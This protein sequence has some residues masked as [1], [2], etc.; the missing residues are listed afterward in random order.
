MNFDY[1]YQG[2]SGV[3]EEGGQARVALATNT[4]REASYFRGVL[5][6]PLL[7]REGFAALFDVVQSD[8]KWRPKERLAYRLWLEAQDRAFVEQFA[9]HQQAAQA[10]IAA[11][12]ARLDA[13]D[14]ARQE[15][16][17]DFRSARMRY[18]QV[19]A[20]NEM[21][22]YRV[23]DPVI[24]IHPDEMSF[25][26]FSRDQ[27]SYARLRLSYELFSQI[28]EY[29]CGTTNIDFSRSL[30]DHLEGL[31]SY[32]QTRFDI[33][34]GGLS[35][36][37][38]VADTGAP[39]AHEK[40]IALPEGWLEGFLNVH[41][42]ISMGLTRLQ[43]APIDVLNVL[44]HLL[45]HRTRQSPRA[46][47]FELS[48]GLPVRV[49]LEPWEH[50][51]WCSP[52]SVYH[53]HQPLSWRIW[54]RDRLRTL[55]R[56]LPVCEQV[57]VYLAGTGLPS[58][59]VANLGAY[60]E[61]TLA[62]SGWTDNDWVAGEGRFDPLDRR[63]EVSPTQLTAVHQLLQALRVCE[64]DDLAARLSLSREVATA[65][66]S[67]LAQDGRAMYDLRRGAPRFR[68]LTVTPFVAGSALK[69][70][71]QVQR[72]DPR[73]KL[74]DAL[75]EAKQITI[76]ARRPVPDGYKLSGNCAEDLGRQQRVRPQLHISTE[77]AI[78]SASCTCEAMQRNGMSKGVCA[79]VLA[80]RSAHLA[81]LEHERG[82]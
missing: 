54:G 22:A 9:S 26:A 66:V 19:A 25:E 32:R 37:H 48:P 28:D 52:L 60:A 36:A 68:D 71:R 70:Q 12:R 65:A 73:A 27:S 77:G 46:L 49:V 59:W 81:R 13:L 53:G 5:A 20:R 1:R 72:D 40:R 29:A 16:R 39:T 45:A 44:K 17:R 69:R 62:L 18:I 15:R 31:R 57:D 8:F 7:A 30:H 61:L 42:L 23:L 80:L 56:V 14:Q 78:I 24:T 43:L 74:A 2:R 67:L 47:R 64:V 58:V 82:A 11:L 6:H 79:H 63:A 41:G 33:G 34:A 3:Q 51:I 38:L 55:A 50:S 21:E 75:L 35:S 4:L 76:I 10:R